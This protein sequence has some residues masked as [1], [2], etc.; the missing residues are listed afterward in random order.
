MV[1][2]T[3]PAA[4]ASAI[5]QRRYRERQRN[6]IHTVCQIEIERDAVLRALIKT[7]RLTQADIKRRDLVRRTLSS[8]IAEWAAKVNK[9]AHTKAIAN[10]IMRLSKSDG[11]RRDTLGDA[12][13]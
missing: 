5:R 4:T 11:E 12:Y 8:V 13:L 9:H 6:P 3:A 10:A 1:T 2:L 7:G